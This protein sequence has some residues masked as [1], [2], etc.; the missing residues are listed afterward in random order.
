MFS[1]YVYYTCMRSGVTRGFYGQ[2]LP[3]IYT[4]FLLEKEEKNSQ[5]STLLKYKRPAKY[6]MC[7]RQMSSIFF[8]LNL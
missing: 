3:E 2:N 4:T 1:P 5:I 6:R 7:E 8:F